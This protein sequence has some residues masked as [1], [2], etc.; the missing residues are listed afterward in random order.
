VLAELGGVEEVTLTT[1]EIPLHNHPLVAAAT[2]AQATAEPMGSLPAIAST[3]LYSAP[4]S[5]TLAMDPTAVGSSGGSQP[6]TNLA[7]YL[8]VNFIISLFGIFP[9]Q[10]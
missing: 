4:N 6:H 3:A 8:C 2:P 5:G 9:S 1:S 7:P 10:N